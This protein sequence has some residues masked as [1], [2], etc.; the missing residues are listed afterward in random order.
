MRAQVQSL[1]LAQ[2]AWSSRSAADRL[3][4]V[5]KLRGLVSR[6]GDRVA[7]LIAAEG[8]KSELE[9]LTQEV[10]PFLDTCLFLERRAEEILADQ[11]LEF[12]SRLFFAAKKETVITRAPYGVIGIL[13][14]WNYAFF[15]NMTQALFALTAGNAVCLK[16]SE[17]SPR[18]A[19]EAG[20]LLREA[21]YPEGLVRVSAGGAEEGR[22]LTEAGCDKYILTGSR[23]A[24]QAVLGSLAKDLKP[25]IV[26]LSGSDAY[27]IFSDADWK[28]AVRSLV[29]AAF[30]YSG[31]TCV[32]PRRVIVLEKDR[33]R[34]LRVFKETVSSASDFVN[35][36][37]YLRI[38]RFAAEEK[39]K[40][41]TLE[42]GGAER[43]WTA[44]EPTGPIDGPAAPDERVPPQLWSGVKPG[45]AGEMDWMSPVLMLLTASDEADAV[46]VARTTPLGLGASVWTRSRSRAARI[47]R[48]LR[49]GQ[50]WVNDTLFTVALGE[51][52]FGG[53][54][55]SGFGKTRGAE[56]LLEMTESRLVS[57]DFR[58]SRVLVHLPPYRAD[59]YAIIQCIQKIWFGAG[60]GVKLKAAA[61]LVRACMPHDPSQKK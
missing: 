56:G 9:A 14:T 37:G 3:A 52:P 42:D 5:R 34:F 54:G 60:A 6:D 45:T 57:S 41:Q 48:S 1:R 50:V 27:L 32:A 20:R 36:Q 4:P 25:A 58:R 49:A 43:L 44:G 8:G 10:L 53:F 47:A 11:P 40:L 2:E 16:F 23:A 59:S 55:A 35:A 28:L 30:Q 15:L 38:P 21:G 29:W 46:R 12:E 33:E 51:A 18:V 26:E 31:Q 24:G 19:E 22:A 17:L 7:R 39:R 61:D 13:G